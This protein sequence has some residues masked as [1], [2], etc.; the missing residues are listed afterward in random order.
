MPRG[1]VRKS[2]SCFSKNI[3]SI[4][5]PIPFGCKGVPTHL[6]SLVLLSAVTPEASLGGDGAPSEL[7]AG[8]HKTPMALKTLKAPKNRD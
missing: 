6:R 4:M 7:L 1:L 8:Q 5:T 2:S 3:K